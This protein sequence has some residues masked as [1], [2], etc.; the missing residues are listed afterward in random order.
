MTRDSY[1]FTH[2]VADLVVLGS[3]L[4]PTSGAV[5]PTFTLHALTLRTFEYLISHWVDCRR[6]HGSPRS[7]AFIS[8]D[9]WERRGHYATKIT[10]VLGIIDL[11][12][13][14]VIAADRNT[15]ITPSR[16]ESGPPAAPYEKISFAIKGLPD[17]IPTMGGS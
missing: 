8:N 7:V 6:A 14:P 16:I 13:V 9:I 11:T 3:S 10:V 2:D 4:Y 12:S 17:V 15:V 1:G 5:N